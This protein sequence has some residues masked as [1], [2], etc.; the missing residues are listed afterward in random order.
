MA[1]CAT[2]ATEPDELYE[3]GP[4]T[5][6]KADGQTLTPLATV[7]AYNRT[8]QPFVT[9]AEVPALLGA[10]IPADRAIVAIRTLTFDGVDARLV[11]D[12]T[13]LA[14]S[15]VS[16]EALATARAANTNELDETPYVAA[17]HDHV[18]ATY[19]GLDGGAFGGDAPDRFVV[20]VDMCQ[21]SRAWEQGMFEGL[22]A[23]GEATGTPIPVGVAMTGRWATAHPRELAKLI[24]WGASDAL[25]ITWIDHSYNHPVKDARGEYTFMTDPSVDLRSEVLRLE[26]L[27]LSQRVVVSPFFRFPGLTHNATRL[28]QLNELG[29]LALDA[30][31]WLAKGERIRDGRMVLLHGNGNE[32]VGIE[33]FDDELDTWGPRIRS[34]TAEIVPVTGVVAGATR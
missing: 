1:G 32:H 11:V 21:S 20:T 10:A 22:V 13:S 14:T 18:D 9:T 27:L 7:A 34:G 24:A 17:L 6:G 12:A 4:G 5:D 19:L 26:V 28:R 16:S 8:S 33:M 15:V 23:L 2:D 29:L 30:N 31:A 25:R 3:D